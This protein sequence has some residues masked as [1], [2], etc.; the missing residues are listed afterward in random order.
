MYEIHSPF[1]FAINMTFD[2][3][4]FLKVILLP[5]I[6]SI[7]ILDTD[8]FIFMILS[9]EKRMHSAKIIIYKNLNSFLLNT[10]HERGCAIWK[11]ITVCMNFDALSQASDV[12]SAHVNLTSSNYSWCYKIFKIPMLSYPYLICNNVGISCF[13]I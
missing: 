12:F 2:S 3:I 8:K 7:E 9:P 4:F 5:E 1:N 13:L 11:I 10:F 6:Y